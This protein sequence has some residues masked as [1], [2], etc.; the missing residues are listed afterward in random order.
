MK[1]ITNQKISKH[2]KIEK[3]EKKPRKISKLIMYT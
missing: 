1:T 2:R 3:S